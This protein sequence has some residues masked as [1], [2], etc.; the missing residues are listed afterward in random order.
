MN[1]FRTF[2]PALSGMIA[3]SSGCTGIHEPD[4]VE[5]PG[6]HPV[7]VYQSDLPMEFKR[8]A[9]LPLTAARDDRNY[10]NGVATVEPLIERGLVIRQAFEVVDVS[11]D[12]LARHTGRAAWQM[13]EPLPPDLFVRIL[14]AYGCDGIMFSHLS[15][16][17]P[18]PPLRLG[19]RMKLVAGPE[20]AIVWSVDEV[21]DAGQPRVV[22][23]ARRFYQNHRWGVQANGHSRAILDS[24]RRF[25]AYAVHEALQTLG[26]KITNIAKVQESTVDD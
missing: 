24:P 13:D 10:R 7:N 9:V 8:V 18:Y 12:W 22:N 1:D 21:F 16:Y 15:E 6:Y 19:L 26:T 2:L 4:I 5:G 11:P 25:G 17:H 3:L 14:K 23:S 20:S